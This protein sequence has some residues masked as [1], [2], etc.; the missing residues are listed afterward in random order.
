MSS[1]VTP[2]SS[3]LKKDMAETYRTESFHDDVHGHLKKDM[4]ETHI[5]ESFHYDVH[6][7][8]KKVT[9]ETCRTE[10]IHHDV[11]DD[12]IDADYCLKLKC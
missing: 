8:L 2:D 12:D 7:H 11:Y 6:G 1:H 5:T 4:A 10:S 3:H 9:E